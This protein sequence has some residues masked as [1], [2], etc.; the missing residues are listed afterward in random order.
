MTSS[1][2]PVPRGPLVAQDVVR[3]DLREP[4][5]REEAGFAEGRNSLILERVGDAIDVEITLPTGV[6]KTEAFAVNL[7]GP[8]GDAPGGRAFQV[9]L[10]RRLPDLDAVRTE[11]LEE[12]EVLGL[13]AAEIQAFVDQ[14]GT[15]PTASDNR[16]LAGTHT[17]PPETSVE[18]RYSN[19]G[20]AGSSTTPSSSPARADRWLLRRGVDLGRQVTS[21]LELERGVLQPRRTPRL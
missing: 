20:G 7:L 10:N 3:L 9:G 2:D 4:P 11:L 21:G 15:P 6:L 16:F 13:D 12:A 19:A 8:L 5:T 18:V 17:Q 1:P 14:V